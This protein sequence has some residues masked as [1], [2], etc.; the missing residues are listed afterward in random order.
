[1]IPEF[2]SLYET[3]RLIQELTKNEMDVINI[4]VNQILFAKGG[5]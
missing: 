2:L 4:V 5:M 3:E 1:M